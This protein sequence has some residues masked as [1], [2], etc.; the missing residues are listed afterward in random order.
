MRC[1]RGIFLIL[2]PRHRASYDFLHT[3]VTELTLAWKRLY[4][5]AAIEYFL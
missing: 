2:A 5:L 1:G 4:P 3:I